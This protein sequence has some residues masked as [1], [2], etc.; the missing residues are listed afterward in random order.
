MGDKLPEKIAANV[1]VEA[2]CPACNETV[3]LGL[4][5]SEGYPD[6]YQ[7]WGV[8]NKAHYNW[9]G[10]TNTCNILN[11]KGD[12]GD[13]GEPP[14][15]LKVTKQPPTSQIIKEAKENQQPVMDKVEWW[16][17]HWVQAVSVA[18]DLPT[19]IDNYNPP[20]KQRQIQ[21]MA[22]MHDFATLEL[23]AIMKKA[24]K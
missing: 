14:E 19:F 15:T 4:K 17:R 23:V 10:H 5:K 12:S 2:P 11:P 1:G 13:P 24:L 3:H 8:N 18:R 6:K 22:I 9:D 21:S 7:W 20:E 16:K